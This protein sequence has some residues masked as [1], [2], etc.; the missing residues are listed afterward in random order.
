MCKEEILK[1]YVLVKNPK[2]GRV[3]NNS[4]PSC[5]SRHPLSDSLSSS[6]SDVVSRCLLYLDGNSRHQ[7]AVSLK[8]LPCNSTSSTFT[9]FFTRNACIMKYF[10][11]RECNCDWYN[12]YIWYFHKSTDVKKDCDKIWRQLFNLA[13]SGRNNI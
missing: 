4:Q 1:D 7:D 10:T 3:L 13:L 9:L 2:A 6:R 5:K 11:F 8:Y 12:L